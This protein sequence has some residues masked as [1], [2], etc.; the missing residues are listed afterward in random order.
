MGKAQRPLLI[1]VSRLVGRLMKGR[2]PTGIDRVA[3]AYV[4]HYGHRSLAFVRDTR[5]FAVLPVKQSRMLFNLLLDSPPDF[6][7]RAWRL[8]AWGAVA[9]VRSVAHNES[10]FLNIGHSGLEYHRYPD[11][12]ARMKVRPV[13]MVHDLIPL[14][15]PEFCRPGEQ[16]RHRIR[17][18][19]ILA[20][21]KGVIT[22]SQATL[23]AFAA[24]A[25]RCGKPV[26]DATPAFLSPP[27]FDL[28]DSS[29]PV[30]RPYFVVLGTIEP[31]KNHVLLLQLWRRLQEQMGEQAPLLV[32]IGQRGWECENVVDLL[33]RCDQL[34]GHVL[35][36]SQCTD[37]ELARWLHH[38]QALLFPSFTEGFGLPLVEALACRT[39]VI[40]SDLTVFRE[41]AGGIPDYLDPLDGMGWLAK[42]WDYCD[43]NG[44]SR[45]AQIQRMDGYH[46]PSWEDHFGRVDDLLERVGR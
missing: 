10:L 42:I 43:G 28:N 3:L 30:N 6:S 21:A 26:P 35:E 18:E 14:T 46:V 36:L 19:T 33:E 24:F 2:L 4:R 25:N 27:M 40:A 12:L 16:V 44:L 41:I 15:H 31:R 23:D 34:R 39:P 45:I 32:V 22:N 20:L 8:I 38:A 5:H 17:M 13:F 37:G 7:S 9:K 29:P 1:D 11:I